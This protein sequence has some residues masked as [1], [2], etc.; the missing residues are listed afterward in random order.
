MYIIV[1]LGAYSLSYT[2]FCDEFPYL[3]IYKKLAI[4]DIIKDGNCTIPVSHDSSHFARNVISDVTL[5][6]VISVGSIVFICT[7]NG[8]IAI[9]IAINCHR[10]I[11]ANILGIISIYHLCFYYLFFKSLSVCHLLK[12][13]IFP[14][15]IYTPKKIVNIDIGCKGSSQYLYG[16]KL[17]GGSNH[18]INPFLNFFILLYHAIP[19]F[20][21]VVFFTKKSI[22]PPIEACT[23]FFALITKI[24]IFYCFKFFSVFN[25]GRGLLQF[26]FNYK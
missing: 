9:K 22:V 20:K 4:I 5:S 17:Q 10:P 23:S 26:C 3:S 21:I 13:E 18:A 6:V 11:I 8:I 15:N 16:G 14:K 19:H 1:Y 12:I 7:S 25:Y 24:Y 2:T